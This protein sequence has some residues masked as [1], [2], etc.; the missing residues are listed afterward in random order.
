[1][2]ARAST[3]IRGN[4]IVDPCIAKAAPL[5]LDVYDYK[6][7]ELQPEL[8]AQKQALWQAWERGW[9]FGSRTTLSL[10][11]AE[12]TGASGMFCQIYYPKVPGGKTKD[13]V[14]PPALVFRGSEMN[15]ADL[16][17]IAITVEMDA[18][19]HS[20]GVARL[21]AKQEQPFT[22]R[23]PTISPDPSLAGSATAAQMRAKG[24]IDQPLITHSRG[25]KAVDIRW[26]DLFGV[27]SLRIDWTGAADLFYG[28]KGD[29]PTNISQ[30]LGNVPPA[31]KEAIAQARRAAKE[32][33]SDWNGRLL[34]LG[35]SLGG[36]L[37]SAAAVAAR[38]AQ[39]ELTLRC[40][41]FNAAGL[42]VNTA[43]LAG[44]SLNTANEIPV[45]PLSVSGDILTSLQTPGLI[46]LIPAV[47]RWAGV[48]LPPAVANPAPTQGKS[49]GA[50]MFSHKTHA[51]K[52][53]PLPIL[54]PIERN[55]VAPGHEFKALGPILRIAA[56][57]PDFPTFAGRLFDHLFDVASG[58]SGRIYSLQ[59]YD[60]YS[61]VKGFDFSPL[62]DEIKAAILENKQIPRVDGLDSEVLRTFGNDLLE[63]IVIL[64][65]IFVAA[66]D[67]HMWDSCSFTFLDLC[68]AGGR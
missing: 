1:M 41:T 36:G 20:S 38:V 44:G 10:A 24:L 8:L 49:P 60:L 27:G 18:T 37:A 52:C 59:G 56:S 9:S 51:P 39:S 68:A 5:I 63:D 21:F 64:G 26:A 45:R 40:T 54:F 3:R 22:Y 7:A 35:H 43:R 57:A 14:C 46:P 33:M 32:A 61:A 66:V 15:P 2:N 25:E 62:A 31:Y 28:Q 23:V 16:R 17:S 30:S 29:W 53:T 12:A 4:A 47:L 67:Y 34:I 55:G 42:H 65:R 19:L 50:Q 13:D 58:G 48:T 6:D 11:E